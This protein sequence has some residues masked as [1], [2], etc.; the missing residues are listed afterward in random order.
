[1]NCLELDSYAAHEK[2]ENGGLNLPTNRVGTMYTPNP[3]YTSDLSAPFP[4]KSLQQPSFRWNIHRIY[5]ESA[6][7]LLHAGRCSTH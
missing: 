5:S 7:H 2:R 6:F 3:D 1:M 4:W